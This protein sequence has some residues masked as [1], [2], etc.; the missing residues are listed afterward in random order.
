MSVDQIEKF[1]DQARQNGKVGMV[2]LLGG[3]P[4]L[5]PD[6]VEIYNVLT[7]AAEE[8]VIKSIK[9]ETNRILPKPVVKNFPFVKWQGRVLKKKK[10]QPTLWSPKDLGFDTVCGCK[11]MTRCGFSLDK[12]GYLPC[13]GAIMI[14][15][16]FNLTHLYKHELPNETWGLDELCQHCIFSMDANWRKRFSAK[17]VLQHTEE[18]RN[19]TKSYKE[20]LE[21]FDV[22]DFYKTQKPF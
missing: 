5:N 9:V 10:H 20:K 16:L 19:P 1:V 21:S 12:Y 7:N 13:S 4:L 3:E 2:K 8:G 11:M 6:F 17:T 22:E 15:R 14:A 18:E